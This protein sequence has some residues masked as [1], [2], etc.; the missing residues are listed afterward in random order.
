M[1]KKE[2]TTQNMELSETTNE[3]STMQKKFKVFD[4]LENLMMKFDF[5]KESHK[6]LGGMEIWTMQRIIEACQKSKEVQRQ[7]AY[8]LSTVACRSYLSHIEDCSYVSRQYLLELFQ[9]ILENDPNTDVLFLMTKG[10]L[11]G[12]SLI[13]PPPLRIITAEQPIEDSSNTE[14]NNNITNEN[15]SDNQK[16]TKP[17]K[18]SKP[19]K[20][21]RKRNNKNNNKQSI[22]NHSSLL[23]EVS[24]TN[25]DNIDKNAYV[26]QGLIIVSDGYNLCGA[27]PLDLKDKYI[28]LDMICSREG[29]KGVGTFLLSSF[30]ASS[31]SHSYELIGLQVAGSM[32]PSKVSAKRIV[33]KGYYSNMEACCFYEKFGFKYDNRPRDEWACFDPRDYNQTTMTLDLKQLS[34]K[35]DISK[36][37]ER[38][39][40]APPQNAWS[41]TKAIKPIKA[42][43]RKRK[44]TTPIVKKE[45]KKRR[46][47]DSSSEMDSSPPPSPPPSSPPQTP[48]FKP[49]TTVAY[50]KIRDIALS[51]VQHVL[52]DGAPRTTAELFQIITKKPYNVHF[53]GQSP[54]N[55]LSS[56]LTQEIQKRS[57]YLQRLQNVKPFRFALKKRPS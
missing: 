45:T 35:D 9:F 5:M 51:A 16:D 2:V 22:I 53:G 48:A 52:S 15:V 1:K 37:I 23:E 17:K 57:P 20:G 55:T 33:R 6:K 21:R 54:R 42:H 36:M 7:I 47:S 49:F 32:D 29:T 18:D 12:Q 30:I 11:P 40:T 46:K 34:I 41:I 26:V 13:H 43:K 24:K 56:I 39:Y 19:S 4:H 14:H 25:A 8:S 3:T 31:I 10:P 50:P 27:L 38:K 28:T 44:S